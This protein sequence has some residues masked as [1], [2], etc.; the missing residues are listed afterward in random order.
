MEDCLKKNI[1]FEELY[2]A[3]EHTPRSCSS[4]IMPV[5]I[6]DSSKSP[7]FH[8]PG[9]GQ[10]SAFGHSNKKDEEYSLPIDH[11]KYVWGLQSYLEHRVNVFKSHRI[12]WY[13]ESQQ[14]LDH[15]DHNGGKICVKCPEVNCVTAQGD[16]LTRYR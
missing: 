5:L 7:L 3:M 11:Y 14:M 12:R 16:Q 6:G 9:S 15:L 2:P 10:Q 1:R 4:R 13:K 8:A